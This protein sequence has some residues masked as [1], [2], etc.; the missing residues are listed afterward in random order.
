MVVDMKPVANKMPP[1]PVRFEK[2]E[3]A[4]L[5]D[6][7]NATGMSVS[8]I[9]RRSVRLMHKQKQMFKGYAFLLDLAS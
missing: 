2:V 4:F 1:K 8:E 7:A 5:N 9:I 6:A 3:D